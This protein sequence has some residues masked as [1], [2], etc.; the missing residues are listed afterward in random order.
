MYKNIKALN[1]KAESYSKK[2]IQ[3]KQEVNK[4]LVGQQKTLEEL[5]IGL[6][7]NSH[8]LVE[9]VP[10]LAKTLMVKTLAK[11]L[12]LKFQ[13]I[14][15]VPDL[16]PA[17]LIGT[18]IFVQSKG[19]FNTKKGPIFTN[20]LL[21]DEINRAP[22]KTQSALLEAMQEKQVT[23]E[24]KTFVLEKPFFVMATQNPIESEGTYKL[25]EAQ[26]DRFALKTI[27][28]YPSKKEEKKILERIANPYKYSV[29][30]VLTKKELLEIQDF[31]K[32]IYLDEKIAEY[33]TSIVD[34]TR[35]PKKYGLENQKFIE[36][37]ASP[38]A[39]VWLA[40]C[41]K[42]NALF[43]GRGFVL[44]EDVKKIVFSVLRHR[45][46]LGYEALAEEI[47]EDKIIANILENIK[48]P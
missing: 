36:F 18:K 44:P 10:G 43:E 6:I 19:E 34:A 13:R 47:T 40:L 17:D 35:K 29:K 33:I 25:P 32:K 42:A 12:G 22:P 46:I 20:F 41:S 30:Q 38:R 27:I 21:A 11:T 37:G 5:I 39:T 2:L 23:I 24:E 48:I 26:L 31:V 1:K 14:Q 3:C 16:L 4:I 9:G 15:F 45:I 28:G 8:V 7:S